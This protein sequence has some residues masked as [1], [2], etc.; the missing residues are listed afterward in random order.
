MVAIRSSSVRCCWHLVRS[1]SA[2]GLAAPGLIAPLS[3]AVAPREHLLRAIGMA[4]REVM[5]AASAR[6]GARAGERSRQA[7]GGRLVARSDDVRSGGEW[8][9]ATA[10]LESAG[11]KKP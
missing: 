10:S 7:E 5:R 8:M 4:V 6:P 1:G 9:D 3:F 11:R 2:P